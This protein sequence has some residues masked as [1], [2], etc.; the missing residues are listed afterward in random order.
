MR[1]SRRKAFW[2]VVALIPLTS[3]VFILGLY[4]FCRQYALAERDLI[5]ETYAT[6]T[7]LD[8]KEH[9]EKGEYG[10]ASLRLRQ[11]KRLAEVGGYPREQYLALLHDLTDGLRP[12]SA[13]IAL[14]YDLRLARDDDVLFGLF[15]RGTYRLTG[16]ARVKELDRLAE[17]LSRPEC[18]DNLIDTLSLDLREGRLDGLDA[19]TLEQR[20]GHL[21]FQRIN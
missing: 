1:R 16:H 8:V 21:L 3:V 4:I 20:L 11:I 6:W 2:L 7:V 9:L 13:G 17:D 10:F 15:S 19:A 12:G 18:L 14:P 5:W